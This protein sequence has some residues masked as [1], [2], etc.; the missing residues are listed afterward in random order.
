[1]NKFL[2]LLFLIISPNVLAVDFEFANISEADLE[3][4][5]GDF[6]AATTHTSV[7][8]PEA[9]GDIWGFEIG[10]VGGVVQSDEID[11][12]FTREGVTADAN[13][14]PQGLVLGRLSIPM[15][16]T[17]EVG[18]IPKV[19][20]S[21]FEFSRTSGALMWT[22]DTMLPLD[23]AIKGHI[24]KSDI[25]FMQSVN[26]VDTQVKHDNT[27]LGVQLL[28]GYSFVA[29]DPYVG[30]GYIEGDGDMMIEGTDTFFNFTTETAAS[31]KKS[32]VEFLIGIELDL[33]INIGLEYANR[34]DE[35]TFTAKF[36]FG[37]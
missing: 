1:M 5:V 28:A 11:A 3:N 17:A 12:I 8:D 7:S 24:S 31:A 13:Y 26:S 15:G 14:L 27:V 20:N 29:I 4:I 18:F 25:N 33:L 9:L 36:S 30:I 16:L 37:F 21:D 35:N 2:I 10:L 23:L 19:G 34:F 6:S 32:G 22:P